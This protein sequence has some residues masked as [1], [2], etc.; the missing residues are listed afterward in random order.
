MSNVKN[1]Y[2]RYALAGATFSVAISIGFFMQ[3]S[4]ASQ[5]PVL[6]KTSNLLN[7][8]AAE[9][10]SLPGSKVKPQAGSAK[11]LPSMPQE[12]VTHANLP[13]LPVVLVVSKDAPVGLLPQ[14]ETAPALGCKSE[15]L[16][17]PAAAAMVELVLHAPC[18][19]GE[20]VTFHHEGMRFTQV[21]GQ[22]STLKLK[23]PALAE[24]ALFAAAFPNGDGAIVSIRV[25]TLSF[26]DR[27]VVQWKGEGGMQLHAREFGAAYGSEG[28]VWSGSPRSVTAVSGGAGGFHT[29]MGDTSVPEAYK[30]E[31]YT[32]PTGTTKNI[33][34]VDVT[35]EAEIDAGNCGKRIEAQ[36]IEVQ[37]GKVPVVHD[38]NLEMPGC[39]AAGE[40][41]VLK[42]LLQDLTIAQN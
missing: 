40:F 41:L 1:V 6:P 3:S 38:L 15:L 23:V 19:S 29:R 10:V 9:N 21:V 32:F 4:E 31:V 42:N 7:S 27:A 22:D 26:Y 37:I 33:G 18:Q 16:A 17:S 11:V 28:H 12:N 13:E 2:R 30:A 34:S 35:V 25:D 5:A 24:N 8:V 36:S 14:E 20:R 39:D